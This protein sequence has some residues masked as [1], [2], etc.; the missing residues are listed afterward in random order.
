MQHVVPN[1]VARCCVEMLLV[2]GQAFTQSQL[3]DIVCRART[4]HYHSSLFFAF[5]FELAPLNV[6]ALY[7]CG[8]GMFL[9]PHFTR[10]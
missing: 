1:N 2:F 3:G 9:N 5:S 7:G 4:V 10:G 6:R 8:L